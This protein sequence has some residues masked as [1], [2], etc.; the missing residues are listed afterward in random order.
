MAAIMFNGAE[1]FEQI[2]YTLLTEGPMCN[3]VK[4]TKAVEEKKKFENCTIL[5]MYLAQG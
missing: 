5:Y 3:L 4:S 2:I 1:R